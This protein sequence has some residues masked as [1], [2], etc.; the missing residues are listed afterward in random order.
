MVGNVRPDYQFDFH[1]NQLIML[2]LSRKKLGVREAEKCRIGYGRNLPTGADAPAAVFPKRAKV[3]DAAAMVRRR[4]AL[5]CK[6]PVR[7]NPE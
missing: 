5:I 4:G 1:V 6:D 2:F 7:A 3:L